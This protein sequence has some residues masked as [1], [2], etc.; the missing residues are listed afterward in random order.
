LAEGFEFRVRQRLF[1]LIQVTM[2]IVRL[3]RAKVLRVQLDISFQF[4]KS[5]QVVPL[6]MPCQLSKFHI[7]STGPHLHPFSIH[8]FVS[9]ARFVL[10]IDIPEGTVDHLICLLLDETYL[11]DTPLLHLLKLD[12]SVLLN[13]FSSED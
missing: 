11:T 9:Q 6:Y 2:V 7:F 1:D 13:A 10:S 3:S 12:L 8:Q 5:H 4:F